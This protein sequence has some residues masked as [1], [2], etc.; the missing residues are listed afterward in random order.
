MVLGTEVTFIYNP[1]AKR[2]GHLLNRKTSITKEG[3]FLPFG[4]Q[5]DMKNIL[6]NEEIVKKY[7]TV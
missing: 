7:L 3:V 5:P 6:E 2:L 1:G 4:Y